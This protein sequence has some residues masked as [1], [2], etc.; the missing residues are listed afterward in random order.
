MHFSIIT[1]TYKRVE[2]L[3][4]AVDS[5]RNQIYPNWEMIIVND[6]PKDESY[7]S[8]ERNINDP[9]IRYL[10][11]D[12]NEGVNFSRNRALDS[13][14]IH[15][16]WVI[17]LD[18]DDYLSPDTLDNFVDLIKSHGDASWFITNRAHKDGT[19]ITK[20]PKSDKWYSYAMDY[21][22]LRRGKGDAT[23][24]IETKKINEI[25]FSKNIK[26]AEEWLFFYQ[27]GLKNKFF[28]HDHNSTITDGYDQNSGLNF[29][30]RGR[31]NQLIAILV[32]AY[33]GTLLRI[34]YHPTFI[35]YIFMRFVR[36][37]VKP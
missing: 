29:R 11:N 28:Y 8:F 26:Q 23:H 6:S 3:K 32:L 33:E 15:S 37:L 27:L 12:K 10:K 16:E 24:C 14:S 31:K 5:V 34:I 7:D 36:A 19:P 22:I 25:R 35:I 20:F 30:K 21:L 4:R 17:F 13:I 9:R 2:G 1:P 18:D